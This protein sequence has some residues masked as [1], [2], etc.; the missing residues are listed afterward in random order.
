MFKFNWKDF[1]PRFHAQAEDLLTSAL[2]KDTKPPILVDRIVV[3]DLDM[4]T[5]PPDLEILEIGNL[6]QDKF[7]GIFKLQY[8]GDASIVLQTKV[9]ANPLTTRAKIAPPFAS[10]TGMLFAQSPLVVP[11]SLRLSDV[12]LSGI[13][14]LVFSK[15]KGVTLVF[16]NDP[17]ESVRVSSSFDS[18]LPIKR[19]LQSEIEKVLRNLFQE[20]LP[21]II[22]KLSLSLSHPHPTPPDN[23]KNN[24]LNSSKQLDADAVDRLLHRIDSSRSL[25]REKDSVI[26]RSDSPI[27]LSEINPEIA[28]SNEA[29]DYVANLRKKYNTLNPSTPS[30][31]ETLFRSTLSSV[32]LPTD[33]IQPRSRTTSAKLAQQRG[34]RHIVNI[35]LSKGSTSKQSQSIESIESP[36]SPTTVP[37]TG[38]FSSWISAAE[39]KRLAHEAE[40]ARYSR[41][42]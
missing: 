17:L 32:A 39:E 13:I 7:R 21:A 29:I 10:M 41:E 20:D 30:L 16:R 31:S 38:T 6:G 12:V 34:K 23:S 42:T 4:G 27:A 8:R 18:I 19:F 11:M 5:E 2:N 24:N 22:Y 26:D 1:P 28:Y 25:N 15:Q 3:K 14:I 9:Q 36:S 37:E 33:N 35:N 40:M